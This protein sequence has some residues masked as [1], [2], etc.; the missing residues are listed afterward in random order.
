M[1][2][3]ANEKGDADNNK[4]ARLLYRPVGLVGSLLAA[5]IAS[6]LFKA[7]WTRV[8]PGDE[9]PPGPLEGGSSTKEI[10]VAA[11]LQGAIFAGVKAAVDRAGA[12]GFE[13]YT[14]EW[15]GS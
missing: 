14:G 10:V 6:A 2:P 15:P 9:E 12:R 11:V 4:A 13:K 8:G 5:T 1:S 3:V 7:I